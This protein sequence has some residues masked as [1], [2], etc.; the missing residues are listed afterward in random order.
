M[1]PETATPLATTAPAPMP[2]LISRRG[3]VIGAVVALLVLA[4]LLP[5]QLFAAGLAEAGGSL[6]TNSQM[7]SKVYFP[8]ILIPA[9]AI[10]VAFIDFALTLVILGLLLVWY[11]YPPDGKIVALPFFVCLAVAA[12][13]GVGV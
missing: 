6:I 4:G 12:A 1:D 10:V 3:T 11:Q 5:W 2:R 7:V 13:L 9:S 8:R